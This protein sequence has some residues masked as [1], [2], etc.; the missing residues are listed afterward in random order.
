LANQNSTNKLLDRFKEIYEMN[1]TPMKQHP[2]L[3]TPPLLAS[4]MAIYDNP[5]NLNL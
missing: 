5:V 2:E 1:N 3:S 4:P